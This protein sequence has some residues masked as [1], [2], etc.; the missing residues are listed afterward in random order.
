[1]VG[2]WCLFSSLC[3]TLSLLLLPEFAETLMIEE[4]LVRNLALMIKTGF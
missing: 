2:T 3:E 1:M 4:Q